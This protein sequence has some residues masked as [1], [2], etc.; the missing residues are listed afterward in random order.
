M[1][2]NILSLVFFALTCQLFAQTLPEACKLKIGTNLSGVSDY[3]T[4][5]PFVDLMKVSRVWYSKDVGNPSEPFDSEAA[6][7]MTYRADGYPTH[8]P[9]VVAGRPYSQKNATIWAS[10]TGWKAGNYVVLFD[11]VGELSF[12][13]G[14]SDL[15]LA[16][17]NKYSFTFDKPI[18]NTLEMTIER[19][20]VSDPIRN[21]RVLHVDQE[22]TY[23]TQ[24]FNPV[25][26]DK[27]LMF[28]SVRFMD[29]GAVNNWGQNNPW[30][31]DSPTLYNW[32]ERSKLDYYTYTHSKGIPYEMMIKLMND[33]DL[34]GW[35]CVPHRASNEYIDKM[36]TLFRN[37]VEPQ[38]ELTVEY[39]NEIWNWMFGQT[40]WCYKYGCEDTGISWPEGIVSYVQ[41]C[42]DRWTAV[43][44]SDINRIKRAVALQTGWV[45]VSQ[46]I[47]YKMK[48]N[49]FDVISPTYYFGLDEA[50]DAELDALGAAATV[51]DIE[52]RVR[53]S[54][55]TNEK[56]WLNEIKTTISD[57]LKKP[58]RF[59]EGGQHIT[60]TP[61]GEEPTYSQALLDIQRSPL[62]YEMYN[63]WY[64]YIRT[65]Q[66]GSQPLTLMNFALIG[67]R[68][69]QYGSWGVLESMTQDVSIIPA[70]KYQSTI[71]NMA[72]TGCFTL[73]VTDNDT[74][75]KLTKLYPNPFC[76]YL[77]IQ[78][79]SNEKLTSVVLDLNG[80]IIKTFEVDSAAFKADLSSLTEG[81]YFLKIYT[82]TGKTQTYKLI[83]Q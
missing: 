18:N 60:P 76:T 34:D 69:A 7:S 66:S 78:N 73:S 54:W 74:D 17:P 30:S 36:A 28:K 59:Y 29:W 53:A 51:A 27:L 5:I 32:N 40:N 45:D 21:I 22:T 67:E 58:M 80:R 61:F 46:K 15:T 50:A 8:I 42:L 35:V 19:S 43:Y 3:G 6:D 23:L 65:L 25:W 31:W 72:G 33:Y 77:T 41:N 4:E 70:P 44:G 62:M 52:S 13:G 57:S 75:V 82:S 56:R 63:D 12:S 37:T 48:P 11:G 10:T 79:K 39:S 47:A 38:R 26:L 64:D 83:K 68:S 20:L 16:R 24:P 49:S 2:K 9:Q 1:K 14:L 81:I 55:E 71:E